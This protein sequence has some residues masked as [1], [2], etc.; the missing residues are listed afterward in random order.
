M[1]RAEDLTPRRAASRYLDSRRTE[2]TESTYSTYRY[3]LKLFV[4]W[5]EREGIS[6]VGDLDGWAIDEFRAFR[7][8]EGVSAST[9][10]NELDTLSLFAEYLDRIEATDDLADSV[11]VPSVPKDERS[12]DV[13]LE[14]KRAIDLIRSYRNSEEDYGRRY[15]ALLEIAW[16]TGAR[17][18][19]IRG[20]DLRDVNVES[21]YLSFEHRPETDTPL[22][23]KDN[24]ERLAGIGEG[25]AS[26][27]QAYIGTH[28]EDAHD[29]YGRQPLFVTIQGNRPS[30]S[31]M[32]SWMYQ[33]TW[34]CRFVACPHGHDPPTC[35]YKNY[36]SASGC[37]SARAPHHVRTGSLS[38][39]RDRG[40]PADV[41]QERANASEGTI[42]EYYD[43]STKRERLEHRRRKYLD[44]LDIE[45]DDNDPHE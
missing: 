37:P 13:K 45:N 27:L 39:H 25:V 33:A 11:E 24:G 19:A 7:A 34:P 4:E 3:R 6:R 23:K 36:T 30:A 1:S 43:K 16:H 20:L 35:E 40:I 42:A 12:R 17:I 38:W 31:A 18:G 5:C 15:H 10:H 8:G 29:E 44:N 9:L 2:V 22:K 26:A 32:R 21:R 14:P 28:R 41:L